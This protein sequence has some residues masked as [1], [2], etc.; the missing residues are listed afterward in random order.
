M[1]NEKPRT[2]LN[3]FDEHNSPDR[4]SFLKVG[5]LAAA[6]G[7]VAT[8]GLLPNAARAQETGVS[9]PTPM[10]PPE[11][12]ALPV[13][14]EKASA[15]TQV[16][17]SIFNSK[18]N[19]VKGWPLLSPAYFILPANSL[20]TMSI[21]DYDDG[22]SPLPAGME[23]YGKVF[24]TVGNVAIYAMNEPGEVVDV[25]NVGQMTEGAHS[26]VPIQQV[27]HTFTVPALNLNVP[28]TASQTI[29][30]MFNT[31]APGMY[32]WLCEAPCGNAPSGMGGPMMT[33]G[34]MKGYI[35]V[36]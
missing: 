16:S 12:A 20:I 32:E 27:A 5:A 23:K 9:V 1:K 21:N 11:Q 36:K 24:G 30:F 34:F 29:T 8:A 14:L 7:T 6:A 10:S 4:R 25:A 3:V 31:G 19:L 15:H 18:A 28:L 17:L 33:L 2:S 35:F 22:P 26:E 13:I